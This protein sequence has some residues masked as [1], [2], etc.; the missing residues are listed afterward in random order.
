MNIRFYQTARRTVNQT[1]ALMLNKLLNRQQKAIIRMPSAEMAKSLSDFLWVTTPNSFIPHGL[2]N[3]DSSEHQPLWISADI[4][5]NPIAADTLFVC[6]DVPQIE[7]SASDSQFNEIIL[8]FDDKDPAHI[9]RM[10]EFWRQLQQNTYPHVAEMAY[11][12]DK[13]GSWQE[14]AK[15]TL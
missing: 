11:W 7:A 1:L 13:S 10:R 8:L 2:Q 15:Q 6:G 4:S 5:D 12:Q 3:V 9:A 14:I